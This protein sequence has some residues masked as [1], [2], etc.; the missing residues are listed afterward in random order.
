MN[1]KRFLSLLLSVFLVICC[2]CGQGTAYGKD[3]EADVADSTSEAS[4]AEQ[5]SQDNKIPIRVSSETVEVEGIDREFNIFFIS[6]SHISLCDDMDEELID[7]AAQ[8]SASFKADGIQRVSS[9]TG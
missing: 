4:D 8:Q 9:E 6:D 7:R 5:A 3:K 2:A 1:S